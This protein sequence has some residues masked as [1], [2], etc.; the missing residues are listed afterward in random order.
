VYIETG[1]IVTYLYQNIDSGSCFA[2]AVYHI[3]SRNFRPDIFFAPQF[4]KRFRGF[5]PRISWPSI[6]H[7]GMVT[8][9]YCR[10][11]QSVTSFVPQECGISAV[12]VRTLGLYYNTETFHFTFMNRIP[13]SGPNL[14]VTSKK[15]AS[16]NSSHNFRIP[17]FWRENQPKCANIMRVNTVMF[18]SQ[19]LFHP[20]THTPVALV[21]S[22]QRLRVCRSW[23]SRVGTNSRLEEAVS[24]VTPALSLCHPH[25]RL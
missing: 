4:F 13:N 16:K 14:K 5:P 24:S 8:H 3:Y 19:T 22:T 23:P 6:L 10:S 2:S 12:L 9:S 21:N 25:M 18:H 11:W 15:T 7:L 20:F 1:G 17:I